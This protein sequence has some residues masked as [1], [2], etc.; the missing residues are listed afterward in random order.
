MYVQSLINLCCSSNPTVVDNGVLNINPR[1]VHI[2]TE[3]VTMVVHNLRYNIKTLS[4][5]STVCKDWFALVT[6]I[7]WK[8]ADPENLASFVQCHNRRK[9][10]A[11]FIRNIHFWSCEKFWIDSASSRPTF[12]GLQSLELH[13][14]ALR[15]NGAQELIPYLPTSLRRL[16][17]YHE[18]S[19][20]VSQP[21]TNNDDIWLAHIAASCPGLSHLHLD[22][23]FCA[24]PHVLNDLFASCQQLQELT[25]T[26][27]VD[28]VLSITSIRAI[29][30][31][32]MLE[33]LD[34]PLP[35][36]L[37]MVSDLTSRPKTLP[38]IRELTVRFSEGAGYAPGPY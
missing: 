30:A 9:E 19:D 38:A 13:D 7:L 31:L 1:G 22:L 26:N 36:T 14:T 20:P 23:E 4:H 34:F 6:P 29:F 17:V 27:L 16:V 2:P 5:L 35:L 10:Y 11:L 12:S 3:L 18:T 25:F 15:D 8:H 28:A 32:P 37:K 33:V 24:S 21:E